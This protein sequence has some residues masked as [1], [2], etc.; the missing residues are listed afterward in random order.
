MIF[1][2]VFN[3]HRTASFRTELETLYIFK[4]VRG[5]SSWKLNSY[6]MSQKVTSKHPQDPKLKDVSLARFRTLPATVHLGSPAPAT[7]PQSA[8]ISPTPHLLLETSPLC[9]C[10]WSLQWPL[11]RGEAHFPRVAHVNLRQLWLPQN[12]FLAF[13]LW[14]CWA[15][16]HHEPMMRQALQ[17]LGWFPG[18][19]TLVLY[20]KM[21]SY[22]IG[23]L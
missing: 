6:N 20:P 1:G 11:E 7:Y 9:S 2:T 10:Q 5:L 23:Y 21:K 15:V 3:P 22:I 14:S 16:G 4:Q 18:F 12:D 17:P 19:L 8:P 13:P